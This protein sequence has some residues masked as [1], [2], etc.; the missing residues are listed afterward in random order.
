MSSKKRS[1]FKKVVS[2]HS[3]IVIVEGIFLSLQELFFWVES[4]NFVF[5]CGCYRSGR[6]SSGALDISN[7]F[8]LSNFPTASF[9]SDLK[10]FTE[11]LWNK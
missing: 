8:Q 9:G 1:N 6:K 4:I 3:D 2:G 10:Q 7:Y 5:F 11:S